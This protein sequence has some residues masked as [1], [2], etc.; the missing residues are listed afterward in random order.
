[1]LLYLSNNSRPDI[2]FAVH[3]CA[4][5]SHAPRQIHAAAVKSIG[6]YLIRTRDKGLIMSPTGDLRV[7]CYVDADFAGLWLQEDQQ[8]PLSV[9][10]RTGYLIL[11]GGCPLTWTSKLQ[12]EVALLTIG[13][14]IH[15]PLPIYEKAASNPGSGS[16]NVHNYGIKKEV[17]D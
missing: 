1:M 16:R 3:Q 14:K 9:K 15:C 13:A 12:A 11:I 8:D 7:D 2:A 5:F 6:R 10:S 17:R 4:R